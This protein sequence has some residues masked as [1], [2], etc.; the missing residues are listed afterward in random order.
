VNGVRQP[1]VVIEGGV[2]AVS[3]SIAIL[4]RFSRPHTII[5]TTLS[6]VGLY[7][8]AAEAGHSSGGLDLFATLI[9]AWGVNLAI[10]G[11]NQVE[12]VEID[13][14]NKPDLPIAAGDLT[15]GTARV[16]VAIAAVVPVAMAVTQ[17]VLELVAVL[18]ALVVGASYS[19]PP[20]RLKRFP[21]V[22]ALSISL[23]RSVVVNL[24]VFGHFAGSLEAVPGIVWAL[25]LFVVPFGLA[26]ALLKDV[27]DVPGDRQF[28]I[29]TFSVRLGPGRVVAIAVALLSADYVSMSVAGAVVLGAVAVPLWVLGHAA[30]LAVLVL[31]WRGVHSH[32]PS[33]VA[34]FYHRVWG[35]FF[36]EYVLVPITVIV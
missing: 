33:S 20:L 11:L 13:R 29:R 34:R 31:A 32:D 9:A 19:L 5:G 25:T 28:S 8:I 22:A 3:D 24:G 35:L 30:A 7:A 23:V 14:I 6:V 36:L 26:I 12:D 18:T 2:R 21:A 1:A 10:V 4:W 16:I 27:P 15:E 17:G